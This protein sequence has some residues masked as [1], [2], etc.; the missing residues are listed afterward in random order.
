MRGGVQCPAKGVTVP[1]RPK[2]ALAA[3][4]LVAAPGGQTY[5]VQGQYII[6]QSMPPVSCLYHNVT[7]DDD[8]Y[9][10]AHDRLDRPGCITVINGNNQNQTVG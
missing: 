2:L 6:P 4:L 1:Y 7:A 8:D 10:E 3:P 9:C 5:A